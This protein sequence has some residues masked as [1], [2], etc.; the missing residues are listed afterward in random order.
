MTWKEMVMMEEQALEVQGVAALGARRCSRRSRLSGEKWES[1]TPMCSRHRYPVVVVGWWATASSHWIGIDY[2]DFELG[3]YGWWVTLGVI[4]TGEKKTPF[5][6]K[7][8]SV[9]PP[10]TCDSPRFHY[11]YCSPDS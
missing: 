7:T 2:F 6:Y 3:W 10:S 4:F 1:M 11:L 8:L 9:S 5:S